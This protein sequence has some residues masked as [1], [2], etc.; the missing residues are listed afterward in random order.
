M[1]RLMVVN[2]HYAPFAYGGATVVAE[3]MAKALS[4]DHGWKV[5]AVTSFYDSAVVP[6]GMKRYAIDGIDVIGICI[7]KHGLSF[8]ESYANAAFDAAIVAIAESFGPDVVHVH[9]VQT[10]GA[11]FIPLLARHDVPVA[12]TLHDA[13]WWCERQ[14]MVTPRGRY[15]DQEKVDLRLCR[16]CVDDADRTTRRAA[17]LSSYLQEA[18]L[19]L[20][21]SDFFRSLG[22]ANGLPAKRCK[23]NKNGVAMPGADYKRSA[24]PPGVKLRFGFVGGPGP[25][26]GAVQAL[27]AFRSVERSDYELVVVDAAQNNASSWRSGFDWSVPGQ[28]TFHPAYDM[29]TIDAFFARIDVLLFPSQWKES[30]GLTVREA[31]ARDVWVVVSDAGGAAEDCSDGVNATLIPMTPDHEPLAQ[32]IEDLLER[33]DALSYRNPEAARITAI[34][35]QARQLD[36]ILGGLVAGRQGGA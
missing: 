6:Y 32:A 17:A 8:A 26:K 35:A 15:C 21:P 10:L 23:T 30:F 34:V 7:P 22:V 14:F 16:H 12:V 3:N 29:T 9:S 31:M 24:P 4:R 18:S 27:G 28:L 25:N 19:Y 5:L 11:S 13:W 1:K 33:H 20:F 36:G 2:V